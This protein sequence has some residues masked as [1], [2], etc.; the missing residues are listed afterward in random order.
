VGEADA[1]RNQ[2]EAAEQ[3][4]VQRSGLAHAYNFCLWR[5]NA[6]RFSCRL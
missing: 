1:S 2:Q 3:V 4:D 5:I 6:T